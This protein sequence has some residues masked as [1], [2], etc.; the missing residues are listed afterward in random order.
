MRCIHLPRPP[1]IVCRVS[2]AEVQW[3][4]DADSHEMPRYPSC[5]TV[6]E[7]QHR[8]YHRSLRD[9]LEEAVLESAFD[10]LGQKGSTSEPA[11]LLHVAPLG[12]EHISLTGDHIWPEDAQPVPGLLRP[13][14]EKRAADRLSY[15]PVLEADSLSTYVS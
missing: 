7:R 5:G 1:I 9:P 12:W 11:L 3:V 10:T 15:R 8:W 2:R 4:I 6:S 14:R 13:L